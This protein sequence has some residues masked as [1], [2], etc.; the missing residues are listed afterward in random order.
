MTRSG[1]MILGA[2]VRTLGAWPSGWRHPGAHSDPYDD[3]AA[4][5]RLARAAE[6]ARLDFLFFGDWLAT[7]VDYEFTDPYLLIIEVR[8]ARIGSFRH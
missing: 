6:D 1:H 7:S 8:E 2:T 4:L 3:P 5:R